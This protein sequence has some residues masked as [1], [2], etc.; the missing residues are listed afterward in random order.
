[1]LRF[2]GPAAASPG[3]LVNTV[4]HG[5]CADCALTLQSVLCSNTAIGNVQ[6][7]VNIAAG[8]G[9]PHTVVLVYT[10]LVMLLLKSL[11]CELQPQ[12]CI[13]SLQAVAMLS[14]CQTWHVS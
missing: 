5:R 11:C 12:C 14:S 7:A 8:Y 6:H 13:A 1:M 2:W 10:L 9:L 3:Q 4:T